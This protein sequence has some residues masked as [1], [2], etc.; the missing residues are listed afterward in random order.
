MK[1]KLHEVNQKA[2]SH[3]K[4]D[5]S[6]KLVLDTIP[7]LIPK[8][9]EDASRRHKVV[10]NS[11]SK[12][13]GI[14]SPSS[15]LDNGSKPLNID[16]LSKVSPMISSMSP[17]PPA[18]STIIAEIQE[19]RQEYLKSG[20]H[21]PKVLAEMNRLESEAVGL[22][23]QGYNNGSHPGNPVSDYGASP[24]LPLMPVDLMNMGSPRRGMLEAGNTDDEVKQLE[25]QQKMELMKLQ[26]EKELF[27]AAHEFSRLKGIYDE[28]ESDKV[29]EESEALISE[30]HKVGS[31]HHNRDS[32]EDAADGKTNK[33][34]ASTGEILLDP[35]SSN[36]KKRY[37]IP[38]RNIFYDTMRGFVISW[39]FVLS[40]QSITYTH[41]Q[42]T[43]TVFDGAQPIQQVQTIE[44][45]PNA[46]FISQSK[47][48]YT[49]FRQYKSIVGVTA[50]SSR[51]NTIHLLIEC[52]STTFRCQFH[53]TTVLLQKCEYATIQ[54]I[55]YKQ[56]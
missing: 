39:D 22:Q 20:G 2:L 29:K 49:A 27:V 16:T 11:S 4:K 32:A 23:N 35:N 56:D 25:R 18:K 17:G 26:H 13:V 44:F 51:I 52:T 34:T 50:P 7:K 53:Q 46:Q 9:I 36:N 42:L 5:S 3:L 54:T 1:K 45:T 43:F 47:F 10:Q 41:A 15:T 48:Y 21:D 31:N 8:H 40:T 37:P 38:Q 12:E 30:A 33:K 6:G 28:A 24:L 14:A 55:C 19:M